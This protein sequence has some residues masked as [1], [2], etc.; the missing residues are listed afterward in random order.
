[1]YLTKYNILL[2]YVILAI[3]F[4]DSEIVLSGFSEQSCPENFRK[5]LREASVIEALSVSFR[6]TT[7]NFV[8]NEPEKS[9]TFCKT[10][11][12]YLVKVN[13]SFP[14]WQLF[15]INNK[16]KHWKKVWNMFKVN[17][18]NTRTTSLTSF[19]CFYC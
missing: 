1:M 19:W 12:S 14:S 10:F 2:L 5:V 16:K 13:S 8:H 4:V 17:N 9:W 6:P 3:S 7:Y 15:K 11:Q 18:K